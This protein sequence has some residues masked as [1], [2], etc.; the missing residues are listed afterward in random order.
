ME[1]FEG[2]PLGNRT[3]FTIIL[4]CGDQITCRNQPMNYQT[5]YICPANRGHGYMVPWAR[6]RTSDGFVKENPAQQEDACGK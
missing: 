4:T 5:K 2:R 1:K 3:L 6:Y